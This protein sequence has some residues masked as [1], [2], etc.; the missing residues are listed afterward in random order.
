VEAYEFG[1]IRNGKIDSTPPNTGSSVPFDRLR[2]GS[3]SAARA[4]A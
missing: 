3:G 1:K 2:T 4:Q